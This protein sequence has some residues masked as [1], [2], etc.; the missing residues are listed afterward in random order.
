MYQ[1]ILQR[2]PSHQIERIQGFESLASA[3][4]ALHGIFAGA[5]GQP[6]PYRAE[7]RI[8]DAATGL[9]AGPPLSRAAL[10]TSRAPAN[11]GWRSVS[12]G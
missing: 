4:I 1:I 8:L 10:W 3:A 9:Y 7:A 11:E 2:S 12:E 5:D 6:I